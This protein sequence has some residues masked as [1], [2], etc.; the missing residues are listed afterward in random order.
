VSGHEVEV[1]DEAATGDGPTGRSAP[2]SVGSGGGDGGRGD[3]TGSL[4]GTLR[5]LAGGKRLRWR[6]SGRRR[7]CRR[8]PPYP[9][10]PRSE[11]WEELDVV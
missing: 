9:A 2:G 7:P 5:D 1:V 3:G 10:G 6:L 8:K 11:E 4:D